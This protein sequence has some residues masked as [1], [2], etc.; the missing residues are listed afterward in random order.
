MTSSGLLRRVALV[1]IDVSEELRASFIRVTRIGELGTTL[2]VT[3][4]W[5]TLRRN[6]IPEDAILHIHCRENFKSYVFLIVCLFHFLGWSGTKSNISEATKRLVVPAPDD[7]G[8]CVWS[9]RWSDWQGR[10]TGSST[11]LSSTD[12]TWPVPGSKPDHRGGQAVTNRLRHGMV[13]LSAWVAD[14]TLTIL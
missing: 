10:P 7:D 8:W 6:T 2:A 12:P 5:R 14:I 4:N 9:N 3:T 13:W 1:R 11:A